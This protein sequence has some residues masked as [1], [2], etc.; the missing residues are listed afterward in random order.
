MIPEDPNEIVKAALERQGEE[1]E[2]FLRQACGNNDS[3]RERV[4]I[5][6][7][8]KSRDETIEKIPDSSA[9]DPVGPEAVRQV[10]STVELQLEDTNRSLVGRTIGQY[11]IIRQIAVG[12]MGVV[13]LATDSRLGGHVALKFLPAEFLKDENRLRRFKQEARAA[14]AVN[15]PNIVSIYDIGQDGDYHYIATEFIEGDN[16]RDRMKRAKMSTAEIISVAI[17]IATALEAAHARGIVHRDIKPGNVMI[18]PSGHVKLLDFGLAKLL[19][20]GGREPVGPDVSTVTDVKTRS[21]SRWGTP[22]YMSPEHL[23]GEELDGRTDIWSLGVV[24]YEMLVGTRPSEQRMVARDAP[25]R[26]EAELD[27]VPD[28]QRIVMKALRKDKGDRYQTAGELLDDLRSL[29]RSIDPG[30]TILQVVSD[31]T[32]DVVDTRKAEAVKLVERERSPSTDMSSIDADSTLPPRMH[33]NRLFRKGAVAFIVL[34]SCIAIL[35]AIWPGADPGTKRKDQFS[36][37]WTGN[38]TSAIISPDG[39]YVAT[40]DVTDDGKQSIRVESIPTSDSKPLVPE[41]GLHY[42]GLSFSPGS[43]Y[44]YYLQG[45]DDLWVLYRVS[46]IAAAVERLVENINTPVTFS[47]NG[48]KM[49]FVRKKGEDKTA[50]VISNLKGTDDREVTVL[51]GDKQFSIMKDLDNNLAWLPDER[52]IACVTS[53]KGKYR[54]MDVEEV[55]IHNQDPSA[56]R[57]INLRP[58]RLIG[59]LVSL[60]NGSGLL[61]NAADEDPQSALQLWLLA[62]PSGEVKSADKGGGGT[63]LTISLTKDG[64]LLIMESTRASKIYI[65]ERDASGVSVARR[66]EI[67]SSDNKGSVGIAWTPDKRLLHTAV[68]EGNTDIWSM[69][70]SGRTPQRLTDHAGPDA[71]PSVSID[72]GKVAFSLE[73]DGQSEVWVMNADGSN[74]R[75]LTS[76]FH[77]D[78][79]QI[80]PDG[81]WVVYHRVDSLID[82]IWRVSTLSGEAFRLTDLPATRPAVSPDGKFIACYM[83]NEQR[84]GTWMIAV[85]PFEGGRPV[86]K[87]PAPEIATQW[88]GVRWLPRGEMLTYIDAKDGAQNVWGQPL[89]G[90]PPKPVTD[91][92]AGK[93]L[94][95][96]WSADGRHLACAHDTRVATIVLEKFGP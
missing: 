92:R 68:K 62:Y 40:I 74:Q 65:A 47:P 38:F 56:M 2:V 20:D 85:I 76:G 84:P 91:S 52:H 34:S 70:I 94:S 88:Q 95:F 16:L 18:H 8:E 86:L 27:S 39:K 93:I 5:L 33:E 3:L 78:W 82:S 67:E 26:S 19:S 13:Y 71:D 58:W 80:S 42:R 41:S 30:A 31:R 50:L 79:P 12:G 46:V 55:D 22:P 4:A 29:Q 25:F 49:A 45:K 73:R 17:A 51:A 77:A 37:K 44:V 64:T 83:Q 6:I 54:H 43:D 63:P 9:S 15:H 35:Y 14:R 21:G 90:G 7:E 72:G 24:M 36:R 53:T 59:Q 48:E 87:F 89:A 96:A 10:T 60:G 61:M 57:K 11:K 28:L 69:D 66:E 23:L 75:P 81:L 1:R 32:E